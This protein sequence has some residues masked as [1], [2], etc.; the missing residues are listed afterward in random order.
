MLFPSIFFVGSGQ[1]KKATASLVTAFMFRTASGLG[2]SG[3]R[4]FVFHPH[5]AVASIS[6]RHVR[7]R[8]EERMFISFSS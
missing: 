5:A 2:L 1:D 8:H 6:T 7:M 4:G 3:M